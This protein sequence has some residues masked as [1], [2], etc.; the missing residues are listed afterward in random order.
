[1]AK[2][3]PAPNGRVSEMASRSYLDENYDFF[4]QEDLS[5]YA[6]RYVAI[7]DRKVQA[8]GTNLRE[9]YELMKRRFPGVIPFIAEV[10]SGQAM[11]L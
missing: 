5:E 1:V 3:K 8:S 10:Q 4:I 9:L 7:H 11:V 6:G 2:Q